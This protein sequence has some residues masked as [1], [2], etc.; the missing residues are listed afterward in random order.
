MNKGSEL[1]YYELNKS[2]AFKN[3]LPYPNKYDFKTFHVYKGGKVLG[4]AV[5]KAKV[6]ELATIYDKLVI[7]EVYDKE[8]YCLALK[9]YTE[10]TNRIY[11]LF[12]RTLFEEF[13]VA[14]NPKKE[15][16]FHLAWE[17]G[18]GSGFNEVYNHFSDLVELIK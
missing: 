12:Q 10:E 4:F 16:C 7:E 18:H 8:G 17:Y 1:D 15:A 9:R 3:N 2:G 11:L 13:G 5:S 14:N 6:N